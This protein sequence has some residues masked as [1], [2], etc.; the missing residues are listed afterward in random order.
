MSRQPD[1]KHFRQADHPDLE[2]EKRPPPAADEEVE[3]Q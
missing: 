3:R 2:D 1:H